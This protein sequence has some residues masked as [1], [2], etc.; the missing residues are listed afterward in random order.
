MVTSFPAS[1]PRAAFR[2]D[3][4][5]ARAVP[6]VVGIFTHENRPS[7]PA[8]DEGYQDAVAPPGQPFRPLFNDRI[9][10]SGQPLALV[11][12]E[13][14]GT[15]RY[16]ASL[17]RVHA[18]AETHQTSLD[19]ARAAAYVPP[20]KREGISRPPEP[21]GDAVAAFTA[22]PHRVENEY[23]IPSE[24]HNPMEPYAT[25]VIW[26]GGGKI[27]VHDKIQGVMNT[28][29]YITGVFGLKPDDVHVVS[30]FIGGAFG[31]GLRPQYQLFLAVLAAL[32]LRRS[33]RVEFTRDQMFTIGYRPGTINRVALGAGSDG[34]LQSIQHDAIALN[35]QI[36]KLDTYT[37]SDMRAPGA[38]VGVFGI[39]SAIDE[40]TY[41][42]KT[43]PLESRMKNH[44]ETD[45][46]EG[47]PVS[48]TPTVE[49][50]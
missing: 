20:E 37:P 44:A 46:N 14:F 18:A 30:P 42:L 8:G 24:H 9:L 38:P 33:V 13:D 16:A 6:G 2:I 4:E 36:T 28:L 27:T 31:I 39:E 49:G 47:K 7:I 15:A 41:L 35:Y 48:C 23:R 34:L 5:T 11:I 25:T 32:D 40:L 50:C 17:V 29:G 19:L 1:S 3:T 26:E 22:A 21:R 45:E 43:D 12:A 10:Y